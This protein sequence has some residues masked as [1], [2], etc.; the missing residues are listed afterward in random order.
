MPTPTPPR[1]RQKSRQVEEMLPP[2]PGMPLDIRTVIS[3]W[4]PGRGC[5]HGLGR[6]SSLSLSSLLSSSSSSLLLL[7]LLP[8]LR[9]M[10]V[11]KE[12][13]SIRRTS[14]SVGPY[15]S[16]AAV[17]AVADG[18]NKEGVL[19]PPFDNDDNDDNH[20]SWGQLTTPYRS[21]QGKPGMNAAQEGGSGMALRA[22][23]AQRLLPRWHLRL[24]L[25]P[26]SCPQ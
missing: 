2:R 11:G 15:F 7:L 18:N 23:A 19:P 10:G 12:Q 26:W 25:S 4:Q 8:S 1:C 20:K 17:L 21:D 13:Y 22:S 9:R 5:S 3:W 6:L 14:S 24:L 16:L